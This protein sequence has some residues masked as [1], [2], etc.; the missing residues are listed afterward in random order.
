MVVPNGFTEDGL[1]TTIT[2]TGGLFQE[3][4][5]LAVAQIYQETSKCW[6]LS[7]SSAWNLALC[8]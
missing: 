3:G 2:F 6:E 1:P 4:I 7:N 8:I 5:V